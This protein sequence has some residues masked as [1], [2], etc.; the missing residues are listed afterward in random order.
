MQF[1]FITYGMGAINDIL[2]TKHYNKKIYEYANE[3]SEWA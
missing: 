1:F 2:L 3:R